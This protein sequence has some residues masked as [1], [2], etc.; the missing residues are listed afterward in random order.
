M[1]EPTELPE[2]RSEWFALQVWSGREHLCAEHLSLR[3]YEVFLPYYCERRR[4]TDRVHTV[5]RALFAGYVFCRASTD[6]FGKMV[7]TPGVLRIVGDG[8]RPLAI[9]TEE[10]EAL[11]RL[12]ASGLAS[13]P[14]EFLQ[15]GQRVRVIAGPL[16]DCEGIVVRRKS[17]H[18][19]V[20]SVSLL[21]RSVA[22]EIEAA[23]VTATSVAPLSHIV[24]AV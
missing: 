18:C 22:V 9:A 6:V 5:K 4:W 21:Q 10:I 13:E 16:A 15:V 11:Q 2:S 20:L 23:Y 12:M 14:T 19:L 17:R 3:G 1:A 8:R 24:A 7:T